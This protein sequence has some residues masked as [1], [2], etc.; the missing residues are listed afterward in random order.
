MNE[1]R[2]RALVHLQ[3]ACYSSLDRDPNQGPC[4]Y[5]NQGGER[6]ESL[7]VPA[8]GEVK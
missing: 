8:R 3:V 1:R 6:F 2:Q 7:Q 5:P 4:V